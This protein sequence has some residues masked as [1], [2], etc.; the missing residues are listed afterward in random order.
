MMKRKMAFAD[1]FYPKDVYKLKSFFDTYIDK[2]FLEKSKK[3]FGMILPHAGYVYSGKTVL[4]TLKEALSFGKPERVIIFGT[5]HTGFGKETFSVWERGKWETPF[6]DLQIDELFTKKLLEYERV[7]SDYSVHLYEHSIEVILPFLKYC[8]NDF[9]IVPIVYNYQN[10]NSTLEMV[11]FLRSLNLEKTL[12]IA[13]SDFNHYDSHKKTL[14]K[15]EL[16]INE[17]LKRNT[18][19]FFKL[20][21]EVSACGIGP[22]SVV[23]EYFQNVK[24]V[25]H[26]TSAEFSG[27]YNFT[28]GYAGFVLW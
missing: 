15:D 10:Y 21:Q 28:V 20:G 14:E 24:L 23:V 22:I 2:V 18:T 13:S 9:K 25:Y 26:T 6:G 16:L 17:I 19:E 8:Y 4:L 12:I 27:D 7:S 5:N 3:N 1:K 11:E